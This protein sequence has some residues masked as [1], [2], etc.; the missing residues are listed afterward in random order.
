MKILA[1]ISLLLLGTALGTLS[2]ASSSTH[3]V[4]EPAEPA[5]R[6]EAD[7]PTSQPD[8]PLP[9]L[10]NTLMPE[11]VPEGV[12]P[13]RARDA[14]M[15]AAQHN[16]ELSEAIT[17]LLLQD[18]VEELEADLFYNEPDTFGGLWIQHEP[19]YRVVVTFTKDGKRTIAE[20][21]KDEALTDLIEVKTVEA[22]YRELMQ[23]EREA[24]WTVAEVGFRAV[25]AINVLENRVEVYTPDRSRLEEALRKN[26]KTLPVHVHIIERKLA[27]RPEGG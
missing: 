24:G 8:R 10:I 18:S 11:E 25:S 14:R 23:S 26:G 5:V 22:T 17:R 20:Y 19:E 12:S 16:V 9:T 1:L 7:E 3:E 2:C 6:N 21:V 15:Y 27:V 4:A 13:D